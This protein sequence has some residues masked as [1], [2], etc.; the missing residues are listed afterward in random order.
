M[1]NIIYGDIWGNIGGNRHKS[2]GNEGR[3]EEKEEGE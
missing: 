3:Q 1:R 2:L